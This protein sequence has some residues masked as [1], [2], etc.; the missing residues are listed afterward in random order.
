MAGGPPGRADGAGRAGLVT[1][2]A[3]GSNLILDPDLDSFY[4]MDAL[5]TKLPAIADNAGRTAD[6]Q[7][8]V[9]GGGSI[10][11]RI[12]LAGAQG[13]LRSTV[14]AMGDGFKTALTT[15]PALS[16]P[17]ARPIAADAA[18]G[19]ALAAGVDPT[20]TGHV[21]GDLAARGAAAVTAA[22]T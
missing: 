20:G 11:Q 19:A 17:L 15:R 6:L 8:I 21:A 14:A 12:A 1:Q 3:N 5:V 10:T 16:G 22:E 13:T 7:R 9:S 4:V 18:A 2:V